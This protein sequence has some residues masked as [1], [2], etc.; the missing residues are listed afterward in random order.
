MT[1]EQRKAK[2]VAATAAA[3]SAA[4]AAVAAVTAAEAKPALKIKTTPPKE[5]M[6]AKPTAAP[7]VAP[8]PAPSAKPT[9]PAA[10]SK[11]VAAVQAAA[12]KPVAPGTGP[13][14]DTRKSNQP[15]VLQTLTSVAEQM[16]KNG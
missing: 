13:G 15:S 5:P 7:V 9:V 4:K 2:L 3:S 10:K 8:K 14:G 11:G 1:P 6:P 12:L 16:K